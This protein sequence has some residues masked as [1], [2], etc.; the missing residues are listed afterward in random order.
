M[1]DPATSWFKI[2]ELQT[3]TKA[4]VPTK[5]KGKKVTFADYTKLAETTLTSNLQKSLTLCI[6]S[7][8]LDI[9]FVDI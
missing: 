7:G 9:L 6:R 1:I 4:M 8:L 3:V 5:G 2:V